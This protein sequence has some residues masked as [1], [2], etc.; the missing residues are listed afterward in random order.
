MR[1]KLLLSRSFPA[2]WSI[3]ESHEYTR[4]VQ[5]HAETLVCGQVRAN[6]ISIYVPRLLNHNIM[7]TC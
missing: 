2:A 3:G 1:S 6:K 7:H 4:S 5:K